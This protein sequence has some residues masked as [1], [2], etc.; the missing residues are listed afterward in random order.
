[1]VELVCLELH[2]LD[3]FCLAVVS[4]NSVARPFGDGFHAEGHLNELA[5]VVFVAEAVVE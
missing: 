2:S 4:D 5:H 3:V 1:M